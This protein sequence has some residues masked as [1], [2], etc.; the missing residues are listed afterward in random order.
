M[1]NNKGRSTSDDDEEWLGG[2]DGGY[3]SG[4]S[5]HGNAQRVRRAAVQQTAR[6]G[7]NAG[8]SRPTNNQ[9]L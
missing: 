1:R 6:A 9:L 7:S 4:G 3:R 5:S 8:R 2:D